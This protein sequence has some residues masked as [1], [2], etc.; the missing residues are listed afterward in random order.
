MIVA[1]AIRLDDGNLYALP[2]PA[3]HH[4]IIHFLTRKGIEAHGT[5][6][7]IDHARGFVD[8][9]D[10]YHIAKL[11]NQMIGNTGEHLKE[12]FSEDVW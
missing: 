10:A 9:R 5:Q 2:A 4:N 8:R 3:R 7:F 6:G 1:A 12:L 11:C